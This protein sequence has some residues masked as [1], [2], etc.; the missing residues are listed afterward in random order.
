MALYSLYASAVYNGS[1]WESNPPTKRITFRPTILK[2]V[3]EHQLGRTSDAFLG[4]AIRSSPS[5]SYND[6]RFRDKLVTTAE[7]SNL[8]E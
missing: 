2:T 8:D 4:G 5:A 1:A 3:P 7:A 6:L